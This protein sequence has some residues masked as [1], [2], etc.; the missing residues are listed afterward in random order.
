VGA[1]VNYAELLNNAL[2]KQLR[3]KQRELAANR[4]GANAAAARRNEKSIA[5]LTAKLLCPHMGV[6]WRS[7]RAPSGPSVKYLHCANCKANSYT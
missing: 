3:T 6:N 2:R 4:E 7:M 5:L 1:D